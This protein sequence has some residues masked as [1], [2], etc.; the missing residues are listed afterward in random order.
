MGTHEG[1]KE[2]PMAIIYE[3]SYVR[4]Q[5]HQARRTIFPRRRAPLSQPTPPVVWYEMYYF[6]LVLKEAAADNRVGLTGPR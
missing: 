2:P 3:Y 4:S 1:N 5:L 6:R